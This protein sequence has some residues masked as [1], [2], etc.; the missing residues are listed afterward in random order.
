[1]ARNLMDKLR[2]LLGIRSP[3]LAALGHYECRNCQHH[4][5]NCSCVVCTENPDILLCNLKNAHV[6]RYYTCKHA[7]PIVVK[8]LRSKKFKRGLRSQTM[9]IDEWCGDKIEFTED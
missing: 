2:K 3:S 7:K 4:N 1:M 8:P 5:P 9:V 6:T